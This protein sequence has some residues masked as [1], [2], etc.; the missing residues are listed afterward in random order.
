[1]ET[2]GSNIVVSRRKL[3][4]EDWKHTLYLW[5]Q[6]KLAMIGTVIIVFFIAIAVFA[7]LIAPYDPVKVDLSQ[8]LLSPSF[9]HIFGTDQFGRDIFSRVIYGARIEVGIILL[10]TVISGAIGIAVGITAGYFG[11]VIDEIL[12]RIT[13]IFLAFPNLI[14][15]MALS[16]MLGRG[17]FNA[18]IAISLV[19][20]T[21]IARLS[22][23]E[24]MKIKSLP[25]IEAIRALGA[26]NLRILLLHILPMCMSPVLVQ[27]SLRMGSIILTAAG[28]GFLG[29]GAQ[30]PTPEWGAIVSDGRSYLVDQWWISTFPGLFIALVV[31]GFNLLGD[32]IRDIMDPRIRR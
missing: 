1:M 32:G 30:P 2:E 16:A 23:A 8:A 11:G 18:I 7:P 21:V 15:A 9:E 17:V 25:Y 10:V 24:A 20:W 12:M 29:L 31:L 22:R 3:M 6:N 26:G 5:R 4:L 19:G 27:L 13:D 28:L 14:L